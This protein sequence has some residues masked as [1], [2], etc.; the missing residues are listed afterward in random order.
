MLHLNDCKH[1]G[2]PIWRVTFLKNYLVLTRTKSLTLNF[3]G[4]AIFIVLYYTVSKSLSAGIMSAGRMPIVLAHV[5]TWNE[6]WQFNPFN[7]V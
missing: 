6:T 1:L 4:P 7:W 3:A 2:G 5:V